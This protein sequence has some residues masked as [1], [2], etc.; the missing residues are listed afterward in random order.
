MKPIGPLMRE[1]RLIEKMVTILDQGRSQL[2]VKKKADVD[3]LMVAVDFFRTY[4]DRTHHGKEEDILFKSL[5]TKQLD[6]G[7]ERLM[8]E[9]IADHVHARQT[10]GR[11]VQARDGYLMGNPDAMT[12]IAAILGELVAFYPIHIAKEDKDFFY[13]CLEYFT[14]EEQDEMLGRFWEFDRMLIHEKYQH[15]IE[16]LSLRKS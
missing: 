15:V 3:F 4:A 14:I 8:K 10:V 11:L 16:E 7:H 6:P 1:H 5:S 9:L 2:G 12:E 13:P